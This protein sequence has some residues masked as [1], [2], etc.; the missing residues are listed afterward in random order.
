MK[1]IRIISVILTLAL[2]CA[3]IASCSSEDTTNTATTTQASE[4]AYISLRIN[5]E[6]EMIA[7]EK[8]KVIYANAINEDGE[9]V[10]SVTSLE[11]MDAEDAAVEFTETAAE[12]G[13]LDPQGETDTVYIGVEGND[14]IEESLTKNVRD[15]FNNNGINGHVSEETLNKYADRAAEWGVS[16]GHVKLLMRVLDAYP[17]MTDTEL[18]EMSVKDWMRIL[19]GNKGEENIAAGLRAEY[20]AAIEALKTEYARLFELRA[21]IDQLEEQRSNATDEGAVAEINSQIAEREAELE[22]LNKE[23]KDRA[24]A[25]KSEYKIASKEARRAYKA[26]ADA[27]LKK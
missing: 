2:G 6:I 16:T 7:D 4:Y 9:V 18:L 20:K 1:I 22:P 11:G 3:V 12:L 19:K 17:E 13:Y 25:I 14:E 24:S 21:E 5:P 26:E 23:Y 27:R 8:G 15:Y 10:L